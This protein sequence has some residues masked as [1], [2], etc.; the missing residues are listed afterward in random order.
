MSAKFA[1]DGDKNTPI[2]Q[3]HPNFAASIGLVA[4]WLASKFMERYPAGLDDLI[5]YSNDQLQVAIFN[6]FLIKE[7]LFFSLRYCEKQ[8]AE[9]SKC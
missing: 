5:K 4:F 8:S 3:R 9:C 7:S 1:R 2:E 6:Q